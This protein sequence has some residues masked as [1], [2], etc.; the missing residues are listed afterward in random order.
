MKK[1]II[2]IYIVNILA[3]LSIS[4]AFPEKIIWQITN[5][6]III[7]QNGSKIFIEKKENIKTNTMKLNIEDYKIIQYVERDVII[8]NTFIKYITNTIYTNNLVSYY[9]S[10]YTNQ[11]IKLFYNSLISNNIIQA[12]DSID[13]ENISLRT[14][15]YDIFGKYYNKILENQYTTK[16]SIQYL[17]NI[18]LSKINE[19]NMDIK[20]KANYISIINSNNNILANNAYIISRD[21]YFD[22]LNLVY[23]Y[24]IGNYN[25]DLFFQK[26][27]SIMKNSLSKMLITFELNT[28]FDNNSLNHV[29]NT[30]YATYTNTNENSY[31]LN[32]DFQGLLNKVGLHYQTQ[33]MIFNFYFFLPIEHS[34]YFTPDILDSGRGGQ[35]GFCEDLSL[36]SKVF[37]FGIDTLLDIF[38]NSFDCGLGLK[39]DCIFLNTIVKGTKYFY[40]Y[41]KAPINE[42]IKSTNYAPEIFCN[43]NNYNVWNISIPVF[44]GYSVG[45]F[46][47]M[48]S[49]NLLEFNLNSSYLKVVCRMANDALKKQ[50]GSSLFEWAVPTFSFSVSFNPF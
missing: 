46:A 19:A 7:N 45:D 3:I 18:V 17:N 47:F 42:A 48:F 11:S 29:I 50:Y 28:Y 9:Y 13:L 37:G 36:N 8:T 31:L 6:D 16:Y 2:C 33:N 12:F 14:I 38:P 34:K 30:K 15:V 41:P 23:N 40:P 10:M 39:I 1:G 21:A 44:V 24:G 20:K 32:T 49:M 35:Y 25:T 26:Y 4:I 27:E 22:I 43:T 5:T